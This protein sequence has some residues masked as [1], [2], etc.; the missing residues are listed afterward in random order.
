MDLHPWALYT[1]K[2][3]PVPGTAE[4]VDTL[5]S[6]MAR[7]RSHIGANHFYIHATE[8]S[9]S[10]GRALVSAMR[11]GKMNFEP[12]AAHL[13]HMPAHTLMRVGDYAGAVAANSHATM[14]DRMYLQHENDV[15]G[16]Y[17]FSHDLFFLASAGTME[18][19]YR[20]ASLAAAD[21]VRQ[22]V[23]EPKLFVALRFARW[24]ELLSMPQP[25]SSAFEPLRVPVWH[26]AYGMA[27]ASTGR[28]SEAR[29]ELTAVR[30]AFTVLHV[31]GIAGFYNGSREILGVAQDVLGAKLAWGAGD[32]KGAIQLLRNAVTIQDMF[33]Y[34]EPPDWYGPA[35]ESLGAALLSADDPVSAEQVFREDL[36]RNPLNPR[37]L[38]GLAQ[39]LHA[40]NRDD[41]AIYVRQSLQQIWV[42]E[43]LTLNSLL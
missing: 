32:R 39:A 34:I 17:Y 21:L 26:F 33:Y 35:R 43:P 24:K 9:H 22:D 27:L 7:S 40:Q 14:H 15:E 13:V 10:P 41:D 18:G 6:A 42:G 11:L 4:I 23:V 38:F 31:A 5:E 2:G 25:K 19:D 30:K 12:A 36:V 29:A 3:D 1:V 16:G 8:A 37:S 28:T 20:D